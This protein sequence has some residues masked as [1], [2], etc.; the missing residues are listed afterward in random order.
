MRDIVEKLAVWRKLLDH[1][2]HLLNSSVFVRVLALITD[3]VE[4]NYTR[5]GRTRAQRIQLG[6]EVL[7]DSLTLMLCL[8]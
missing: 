7:H 2:Y 5:V 3:T 1:V 4:A 8:H 6:V